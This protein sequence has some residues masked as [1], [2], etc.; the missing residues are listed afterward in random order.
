M[1]PLM[2]TRTTSS[3]ALYRLR[4]FSFFLIKSP[5]RSFRCSS[6]PQ[7]VTLRKPARLQ[8]RSRRLP[9]AINLLR[10]ARA[11]T[12]TLMNTRTILHV[13]SGRICVEIFFSKK[14][15]NPIEIQGNSRLMING[16]LRCGF[17]C[18]LTV[19]FEFFPFAIV[20]KRGN[21]SGIGVTVHA[22]R[23]YVFMER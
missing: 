1:N 20:Q 13:N 23:K 21:R 11:A 18:L 15:P 4:R 8:A 5:V 19:F 16:S 3:Q 14:Q 7:K 6:F 12:S 2:N 22:Y 10:S 17:L 9:V